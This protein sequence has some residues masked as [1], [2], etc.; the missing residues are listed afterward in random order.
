MKISFIHPGTTPTTSYTGS[1]RLPK[2][3]ATCFIRELTT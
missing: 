1:Y 2:T 3:R